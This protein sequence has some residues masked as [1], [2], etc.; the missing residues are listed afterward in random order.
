M[1]KLLPAASTLTICPQ[2]CSAQL[3][4]KIRLERRGYPKHSTLRSQGSLVFS[5]CSIDLCMLCS[6]AV[7]D[8]A[9]DCQF[10]PG[11]LSL[12]GTA[13]LPDAQHSLPGR[14]LPTAS[15]PQ[16]LGSQQASRNV[17]QGR[18]Q[19]RHCPPPLPLPT[20]PCRCCC[21]NGRLSRTIKTK[22]YLRNAYRRPSLQPL[23]QAAR[24]LCAPLATVTIVAGCRAYQAGAACQLALAS[25]SQLLLPYPS[26]VPRQATPS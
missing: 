24:H 21:F 11:P 1:R 17:L 12:R 13:S 18:R 9:A 4:G 22:L 14:S 15:V 26:A 20:P 16:P 5:L 2:S 3:I 25:D 8:P 19:L 23:P 10:Q 7:I 6:N